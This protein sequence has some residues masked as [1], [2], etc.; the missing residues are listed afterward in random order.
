[1]GEKSGAVVFNVEKTS[2]VPTA[3]EEISAEGV[4]VIAGEG[5]VTI[6]GAEGKKVVVANILGQTIANAV[7]SSNEAQIAAP[8]GVVVVSVEGEAAVKAVVK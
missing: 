3:N 2:V 1:M 6:K 4:K 5:F 7:V 8:A